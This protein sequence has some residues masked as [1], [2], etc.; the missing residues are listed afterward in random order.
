MKLK[1]KCQQHQHHQWHK[2]LIGLLNK[3]WTELIWKEIWSMDWEQHC[4]EQVQPIKFQALSNNSSKTSWENLEAWWCRLQFCPRLCKKLV[5]DSI[6]TQL[7][8][9][10]LLISLSTHLCK[11]LACQ[12]LMLTIS[13]TTCTELVVS[14]TF[15][16]CSNKW[17]SQWCKVL[18]KRVTT[19]T[20]ITRVDLIWT[21]G[22]WRSWEWLEPNT[23][24]CNQ[25][26]FLN[27]KLMNSSWTRSTRWSQ[28]CQERSMEWSKKNFHKPKILLHL[29]LGCI[30][31]T[32][33]LKALQSTQC[34]SSWQ[35]SVPNMPQ[36]KIHLKS[37]F[38]KV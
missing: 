28:I 26:K 23:R 11:K 36:F 37:L 34:N 27:K 30:S 9:K 13:E 22:W 16:S 5:Q 6:Q 24:A 7:A 18:K 29:W 1:I 21:M 2:L 25:M 17:L 19:A 38:K 3:L 10:K 14:R 20:T 4:P 8:F 15:H 33:I 12:Q 31:S 32:N 35:F